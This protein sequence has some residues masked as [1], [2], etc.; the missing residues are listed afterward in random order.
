MPVGKMGVSTQC[1]VASSLEAN[2]M[3]LLS[4]LC[5]YVFREKDGSLIEDIFGRA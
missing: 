3:G 4:W 5:V 2:R 1:M